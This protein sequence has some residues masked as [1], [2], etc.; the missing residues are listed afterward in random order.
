MVAMSVAYVRLRL[1]GFYEHG[2]RALAWHSPSFFRNIGLRKMAC[3][4]R[5]DNQGPS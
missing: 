3:A 4:T 1:R 5:A 2:R